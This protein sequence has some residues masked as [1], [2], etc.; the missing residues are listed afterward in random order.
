[1]AILDSSAVFQLSEHR[2]D[3]QAERE[4]LGLQAS[5]GA[6]VSFEGWVRN[7]HG[8]R[9]VQRLD[10]QAHVTLANKAGAKILQESATRHKLLAASAV[11]RLGLLEIGEIA[12]WVGVCAAHRE[13]AFAACREIIDRIKA[14]VPIWKHEHY[15]DNEKTWIGAESLN[16]K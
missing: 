1:M 5:A 9:S 12:V 3:P 7:H 2:I 8:G 11:H 10:Y 16:E 14:E 6:Y 15:I 13:A 4:R